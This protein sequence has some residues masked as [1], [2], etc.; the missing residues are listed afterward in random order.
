MPT[1]C[2]QSTIRIRSN[3]CFS[4]S[5]LAA[6][7][8]ELKKQNPI[9]CCASAWCPGGRTTANPFLISPVTAA[10]WNKHWQH[11]P[12]NVYK[13]KVPLA[14]KSI[15]QPAAIRAA[16]GVCSGF[17]LVSVSTPCPPQGSGVKI[18]GDNSDLVPKI[19]VYASGWTDWSSSSVAFL[20]WIRPHLW[21]SSVSCNLAQILCSLPPCS[22]WFLLSPHT[23]YQHQSKQKWAYKNWKVQFPSMSYYLV[24]EH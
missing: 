15:T 8:T 22:G 17:Q 1:K 3:L 5:C 16:G 21:T 14:A 10:I 4:R 11:C 24:F 2:T 19:N 18:F 20:E 6:M 23:H 13:G 9:A 12:Q 7:A